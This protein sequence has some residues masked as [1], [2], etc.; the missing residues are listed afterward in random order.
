MARMLKVFVV[1]MLVLAFLLSISVF[2]SKISQNLAIPLVNGPSQTGT[3]PAAIFTYTPDIPHPGDTIVFDAS[4]SYSPAGLIVK[5]TWDFGDGNVTAVTS[6][7]VTHSYPVD[8]NYTV[9][10]TVTDNEGQTATAATVVQVQEDVNFRVCFQGI[11]GGLTVPIP[12]VQVTVYYNNG[13]AWVPIPAR[14]GNPGVT[15][16]YDSGTQPKETEQYRNPGSTAS[17]LLNN[18]TNVEFDIHPSS[19]DVYFKLQWG[20]YVAYWPN[21]TN[22]YCRY[23]NG[24]T[25]AYNFEQG[26]KP[27]WDPTASAYVIDADGIKSGESDEG[28]PIIATIPCSPPTQ[29]FYLSVKTNP[30]GIVTIPGQG[31]YSSGTN[32]SLTAPTYVNASTTSRYRFTYW[33]IDGTSQGSGNNPITVT[34]NANHTATAHY[35]TQYSIIFNQTGL[36]S[37]ATGTIATVNSSPETYAQLPLTLWVDS[38]TSVTYS[39]TSIVPS[40]VSGKQFTLSGVTGPSSP[41]TVSGPVT[42]NGNYVTQY[43]VTFAQTGLDSSATGTVV[44]VNGSSQAFSSLPY[45]LWISSGSSVTY[46][47]SSTVSSSTG[48]KQFRLNTVSGH[49]SPF[50][51]SGPMTVTG[52]YIVQYS[53]TFAQTGLDSTASGTIVTVNG[54]SQ[55][56][57]TLPYTLWVD[58]GT[59]V[60][61]VYSSTITS[62]V[63][64]KQFKLL[65]ITGQASPLTVTGPTTITGNYKTQYY[66]TVSSPYDSPTPASGWFDS[67]T[68]VT[69]SVT[70][71]MAGA[72][73][74]QYVCSGW[75]G[76]GSVPASGT[77]SSASFTITAP[78]TIAWTWKTQY[79]LTVTSPYDSPS[80]VS[81][82]FDSGT[83]INESVTSPTPGSSGTQYVC[84][85]WSGTGSVPAS[86]SGTSVTF[87]I[88]APSTIT[89]SWKTQYY[90]TV[91]SPYD[92]PSPVSGWF[93]S[94]K[95]IT[96][97]VTSPVSGGSGIQHVCTGWSG[98]GS[99]PASGTASSV[100]FT[101]GSPSSISW[102]W[103]TQYQVTF[104]ESGVGSDFSGTVVS[105][106]NVNY[107]V[108][109]LTVSYW[110]DSGSNHSF[111]FASPL[112]V[113]SRQ[114]S[115]NS[116]S[117]LSSLQNGTLTITS[118]GSVVGNYVI[119]NQIT[120][121]QVGV[122]SDFTGTVVI[123]DSTSYSKSQLPVSFLWG[124]G[125]NHSFSF[126]SPLIVGAST[127]QYVWTST[128]GLSSLQNSSITVAAYGS[129]IGNY[130]TQYYLTVSSPYDSPTPASGWFDSGTNVT[131]SVTSPVSGGSGIQY[132]C[133]GWS[134]T[135][136]VPASGSGTSVTFAITAPS[137][138][139]WT[140]KTQ[141]YLTVSSAYG[142]PS[143][144]GWYDAGFTASFSVTTPVS[145][146]AGT[147]Y[148]FT[149]WSSSD[150]GGYTG[151]SAS[152]SVTMNNPI[153]ETASWKTQY[154][155]TVSSLHDSP[156][157]SSGWFDSGTGITESVT[158]PVSGGSGV[159]YVCKGWS[160]TGS[161]PVSGTASSV[162]FTITAPSSIVW[163]WKTQY[164]VTFNQTGLDSSASSAVV[165][166]NGNPITYL[167]LPYSI[168][169]DNGSSISYS[170]NN[171][172]SSNSG[173]QFILIGVTG[174][175]SP[176]TVTNPM[177]VV[178][179]YKTQYQVTFSQ[180]GVGFDF[181]GT[182]VTIDSNAYAVSALPVSFWWDNGS[183][184]TFSLSS[185]LIVSASEQ[186]NWFSTSGLTVLQNGSLTVTTSGSVTGNYSTGIKYQVTFSQNGLSPDF[187][188]TVVIIDGTSYGLGGVNTL[189]VSFWWDSGS[190]HTF[191]FQSPLVVTA[192]AKQYIW[193]GT[194]GL[195]TLQNDT[196]TV[197]TSGSVTGNYNTQYYLTMATNPSGVTSPSG[198]GW[199]DAGSNAT[200]STDAFVTITM[201]SS[202]Y[203][204]NGWTTADM[205]EISNYLATPT[206]VFVDEAKTVTATY[207]VQYNVTFSQLGVGSDF[208][209]TV[210]VIDGV[211]YMVNTLPESFWW[212]NNTVHTFAFQ[213]LLVV[214]PNGKA[215]A[216]TNTTGLS[217]S[218]SG[219]L[220]ISASGSMVGN[221]VIQ[222]YLTVGSPYDSPTPASRWFN[223]GA[224]ITEY[225]TSPVPE[226]IG[227]QHVCI[228][229][230]GT[231][232]VPTSGSGATTTFTITQASTIVWNWKTQYYLIVESNPP[233]TTAISGEGWYDAST[234]VTLNAPPVSGWSF[235]NWNLDGTSQGNTNPIT[236]GMS[237]AHTA[238]ANYTQIPGQPL[239]VSISPMTCT[240]TVGTPVL[241][242]STVSGGTGPYTYQWYENGNP[243][244]NATSP[245]WTFI[246]TRG[247][248][249]YIYLQV[250]DA[251]QGHSTMQSGTAKIVVLPVS[252]GG[253]S[254]SMKKPIPL[255]YLGAYIGLVALFCAAL[256]MRKRKRK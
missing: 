88:T 110:W 82:W 226:S 77:G 133:T 60:T 209:N 4:A 50:T 206:T 156:S 68:N 21:N 112:V 154:Y 171:V 256:C 189:P 134:G 91:S 44:T 46:S 79:Y 111:S 11:V 80:P 65:S 84:T 218:Q 24:Y 192:N 92:S 219:T 144:Q 41:I 85:G 86:G 161:V 179:N 139:S 197:T 185:P 76:S 232:S 66:L 20:S 108:S 241:F 148:V 238:T 109:S 16:E 33:D 104:G 19:L 9:E 17:I 35:V 208:T 230:S 59:S 250:T 167:Q 117:G 247:G 89:W 178:G 1:L 31:Q 217:T 214:I 132:V 236:V 125:S 32:V 95:S 119:Q 137:T 188:G 73:G 237:A 190:T 135:G 55:I 94:G 26:Q 249:Y 105:V 158:S 103:K 170:Y 164:Q 78:S 37:D 143:G 51:V 141:Y 129:I 64:G 13:T 7:T 58:N 146:G 67:G 225:V 102:T 47:Y 115:W 228:G 194:A 140:W 183:V 200:V 191:A 56:L 2:A 83:S 163:S 248:T 142:S 246:P 118:S 40:S 221:Y 63:S 120:F 195:S 12:N 30:T 175:S 98:T 107:S 255:S 130:K 222:Y 81:G 57:S 177:T 251:V 180:S 123:I 121:D 211:N 151:S 71:P 254:I 25:V 229:W 45:T 101:I 36:S 174:L 70:S 128:T 100:T 243:V 216:W 205:T 122:S 116:T 62:S 173:E 176:I 160:G 42:V 224:S 106:D 169:A 182:V 61:Y 22:T 207:A 201:G 242:T 202:R 162:T 199:Y 212:D 155:L 153:T 3:L 52:N 210:A 27:H 114:Y 131:D 231:G 136:S 87:A 113:G 227:K 252:V 235:S 187:T 213:S 223:A 15:I 28:Q 49:S 165:T 99:T 5:Y 215:Y 34:M 233:G 53:V 220:T 39:Y 157:P 138:I 48:G 168:W 75:S 253:L 97:S 69:D 72:S 10:L 203:R 150:T 145:G 43:Q 198:A 172:S 90:L 126:Q 29:Q 193:T 147:Q 196:I 38:G 239:T 149:A 244:P 23:I 74:T 240:T 234:N 54:S 8:G 186:Y 6:P 181:A 14:S 184:H 96:E 127:E 204:F 159:Q 18:A 93:D 245:S 166:V 124:I 152:Q